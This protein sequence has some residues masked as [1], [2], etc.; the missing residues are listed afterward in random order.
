[1]HG[2]DAIAAGERMCV[3]AQQ[4]LPKEIWATQLARLEPIGQCLGILLVTG[5]CR[6]QIKGYD[7]IRAAILQRYI[8][9]YRQSF[10]TEARKH[11]E[12]HNIFGES[13]AW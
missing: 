10:H 4:E 8:V 2:E 9:T 7:Q 3:A 13:L 12:S 6:C 11:T 1:M 5:P